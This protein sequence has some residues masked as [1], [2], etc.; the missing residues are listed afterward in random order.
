VV[1]LSF[2]CMG[3]HM[4]TWPE[5]MDE[6]D[7]DGRPGWCIVVPSLGGER[8]ACSARKRRGWRVPLVLVLVL[9][10]LCLMQALWRCSTSMIAQA[11]SAAGC[12][13]RAGA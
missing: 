1:W 8:R 3:E 11:R 13:G 2:V 9:V 7:R 4:S 6:L 12:S 10:L 5:H